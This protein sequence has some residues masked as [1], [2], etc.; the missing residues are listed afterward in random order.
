MAEHVSAQPPQRVTD[1]RIA[2]G[3]IAFRETTA[4]AVSIA[5]RSFGVIAYG[6]VGI[7]T[8]PW[9]LPEKKVADENGG[10]YPGAVGNQAAR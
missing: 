10:D 4:K 3:T 5:K 1:P 2:V 9:R 8:F 7:Y 6:L